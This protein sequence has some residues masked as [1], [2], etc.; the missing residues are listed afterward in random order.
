MYVSMVFERRLD[1]LCD[2][3]TVPVTSPFASAL[4]Y[5]QWITPMLEGFIPLNFF[6]SDHYTP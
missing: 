2:V 6:H 4:E 3:N 5:M 1:Y